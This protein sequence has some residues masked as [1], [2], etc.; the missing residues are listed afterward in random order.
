MGCCFKDKSFVLVEC[1]ILM[2]WDEVCYVGFLNKVMFDFS[3]FLDL[4]FLIK[5]CKYIFFKLKFIFYVIYLF[6]KIG[7]WCYIIIYCYLE[8]YLEDRI[9]L[10][11]C[12]FENWC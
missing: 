2:F 1:F 3:L 10:I 9:Y 11:F 5:S 12:F 6:E 8:F 4:G 7:Y